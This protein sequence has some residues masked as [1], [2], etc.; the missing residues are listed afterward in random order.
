MSYYDDDYDDGGGY[1]YDDDD[2]G[3]NYDYDDGGGG[4]D[5]DGGFEELAGGYDGGYAGGHNNG[6]SSDGFVESTGYA[7]IGSYANNNFD[8]QD[9]AS[10][11]TPYTS[12]SQADYPR[13]GDIQADSSNVNHSTGYAQVDGSNDQDNS[14]YSPSDSS[15]GRASG[16]DAQV[17][18]TSGWTDISFNCPSTGYD[19]GGGSNY[20]ENSSNGPARNSFEQTSD[21]DDWA[22]NNHSQRST[23]YGQ[24]RG[25]PNY[26]GSRGF[27][28]R[29]HG[30]NSQGNHYCSRDY[31]PNAPN[32]NPYHY[33][34]RDGSWYYSN[35]DGSRYYNNGK[36]S[37]TYTT[38]RGNMYR[39][40]DGDK[41]EGA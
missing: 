24:A 17:R 20:K 23:S 30:T 36:G 40:S 28:Y 22:S 19:K 29:G 18:H 5:Y 12:Y 11:R 2:D 16:D 15:Y 21:N 37:S 4:G 35:P 10:Y 33:S 8:E 3:G 6:Y 9:S 26:G 31:G 1:D 32:Q 13:A 27:E 39:K 34:N 41:W 14:I 7:D 38:P 25:N